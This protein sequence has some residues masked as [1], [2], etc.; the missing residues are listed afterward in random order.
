MARVKQATRKAVGGKKPIPLT[1]NKN[2][3]SAESRKK[4][5]VNGGVKKPYRW[6]PGT[7]ALREIR[8]YQKS[9]ELLL[10]KGPF[11]RL[12][13]EIA[14][15]FQSDLRFQAVAVQALQVAFLSNI[16]Q[17]ADFVD[18]VLL[19]EAAEAYV[20]SILEDTNLEAVHAKRSTI[21]M[22]DMMLARRIRGEPGV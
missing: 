17:S 3:M 18:M 14:Q 9:I 10:R 15:D 21:M 6:K 1:K 8:R 11:A 4:A 7:V 16:F 12:V 22:K 5:P 2:L 20:V 19:Q 13:R